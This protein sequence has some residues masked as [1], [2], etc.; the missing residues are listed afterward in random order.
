MKIRI[1]ETQLE[2]IEGLTT[3]YPYICHHVN[4]ADTRVP[5]HWHEELEFNYI[6][7][8][9]AVLTTA[10]QSSVF[11]K[12]EAFFINSNIL[13]TMKSQTEGETCIMDSHLFHPIFLGGHF[14]SIFS[15]KYLEPILQ[16]KYLEILGIRGKS[17]RQKSLLRLLREAARIQRE[18]NSEFQTRNLFSNIW[19]LLL[20]EVRD[21]ELPE[22][23]GRL[24]N[25]DRI[26]TMIAFIQQHYQQKLSLDDIARSA[27]VSRSECLRCF[28]ASISRTPF[29]YL[30]DYRL[31][32]AER[33]LRSTNLSV[34]DIALQTGFSNG[35]YFGKMF[36]EAKGI[37]PGLYRKEI[38]SSLPIF[39]KNGNSS[40]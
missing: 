7:N 2:E 35:A 15:T 25:Q 16:N 13:C 28:R 30:L 8:G 27:S 32:R 10:N 18:E 4:L 20:E 36:K 5:W 11:Q 9:T 38:R 31:E 22:R 39:P 17:A 14:K 34:L 23:T 33:L 37:S 12:G 6:V 21:I 3:E 29:E 26:Q 40:F 1:T 24:V 19:L